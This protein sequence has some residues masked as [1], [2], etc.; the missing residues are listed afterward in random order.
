M[1]TD[2]GEGTLPLKSTP[3]AKWED[4]CPSEDSPRVEGAQAE[5]LERLE[6]PPEE[7]VAKL[8]LEGWAALGG[9]EEGRR[10]LRWEE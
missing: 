1:C 2:R 5:G 4:R 7:E 3:C 10:Y 8:G 6:N 9:G